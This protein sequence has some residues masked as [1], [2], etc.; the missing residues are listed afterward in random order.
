MDLAGD[1]SSDEEYPMFAPPG[2]VTL[3]IRREILAQFPAGESRPS[4]HR[5]ATPWPRTPQGTRVTDTDTF[6]SQSE[7]TLVHTPAPQFWYDIQPSLQLLEI[8]FERAKLTTCLG[9]ENLKADHILPYLMS[10]IPKLISKFIR[11]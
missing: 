9:M 8:L 6:V 11:S 10:F 3:P 2:M 7:D 4:F 1:T 5:P